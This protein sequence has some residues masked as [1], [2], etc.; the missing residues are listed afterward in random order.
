MLQE[1]RQQISEQDTTRTMLPQAH[2]AYRSASRMEQTLLH[3]EYAADGDA[4][5]R[6]I[7]W[8]KTSGF[9]Y[10]FRSEPRMRRLLAQDNQGVRQGKQPP[11]D[12]PAP[13]GLSN[14]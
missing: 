1:W 8:R 3:Q 6:L 10:L 12:Y 5:S 13:A 4:Y 9:S 11:H 14:A 2:P 7:Q